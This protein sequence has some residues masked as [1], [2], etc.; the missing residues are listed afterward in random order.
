[1]NFAVNVVPF[2]LISGGICGLC[3]CVRGLRR[4]N[5]LGAPKRLLYGLG[6]AISLGA[7][8]LAWLT[9]R[10]EFIRQLH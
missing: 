5:G 7:I 1:M 9:T 6:V 8:G 10:V 2:L 3:L 4:T